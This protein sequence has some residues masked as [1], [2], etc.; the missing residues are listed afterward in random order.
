MYDIDERQRI[1]ALRDGFSSF[2]MFSPKP[3]LTW[4]QGLI[5]SYI[6]YR[7]QKPNR[8]SRRVPGTNRNEISDRLKIVRQ[9]VADDLTVLVTLGLVSR[10]SRRYTVRDGSP[11]ESF[12]WGDHEVDGRPERIMYYDTFFCMD[13]HD[14]R[15]SPLYAVVFAK[16]AHMAADGQTRTSSSGLAAILG[17][18]RKTASR[19][20]AWLAR[21]KLITLTDAGRRTIFG[22][23]GEHGGVLVPR[24]TTGCKGLER[25][26]LFRIL[27]P[28][29]QEAQEIR[30]CDPILK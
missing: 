24:K 27:R 10:E 22:V 6:R 14:T 13:T 20:L 18:H 7:S 3:P 9:A 2:P 21:K 1:Q 15:W 26:K 5:W 19:A 30:R 29:H 25:T 28:S 16:L 23:T 4:R 12:C 17:C 8:P 11:W